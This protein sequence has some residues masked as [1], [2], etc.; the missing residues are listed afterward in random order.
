MHSSL[1]QARV[2]NFKYQ[3]RD[4]K[5]EF[6]DQMKKDEPIPQDF[7]KVMKDQTL[8]EVDLKRKKGKKISKIMQRP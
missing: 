3:L 6:Y 1:K 2:F 5:A 8:K 7:D 4:Q